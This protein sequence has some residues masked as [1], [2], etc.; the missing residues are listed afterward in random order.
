MTN[1]SSRLSTWC[2]VILKLKKE[3]NNLV[4]PSTKQK[5]HRKSTALHFIVAF[6]LVRSLSLYCEF[7]SCPYVWSRLKKKN[8]KIGTQFTKTKAFLELFSTEVQNRNFRKIYCLYYQNLETWWLWSIIST[9]AWIA[10][11]ETLTNG[12]KKLHFICTE[13][14]FT[15]VFLKHVV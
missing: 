8:R 11:S 1:N 14:N 5:M 10:V 13:L 15:I 6:T 4:Q 12:R 3:P 9:K 7:V 2:S